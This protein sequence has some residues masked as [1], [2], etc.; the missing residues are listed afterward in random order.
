M[1]PLQYDERWQTVSNE[2][3]DIESVKLATP[4]Y[5]LVWLFEDEVYFCDMTT[6]QTYLI[7][8]LEKVETF[9][10]LCETMLEHFN[11]DEVVQWVASTLQGWVNQGLFASEEALC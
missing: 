9:G 7:R 3:S 5:V 8:A 10:V 11:E 1:L 4:T 2:E 6:E